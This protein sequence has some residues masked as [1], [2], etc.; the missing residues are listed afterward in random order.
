[1]QFPFSTNF[2]TAADSELKTDPDL[3]WLAMSIAL[4]HFSA[5]INPPLLWHK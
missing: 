5:D 1:M 3:H 4:K 2:P